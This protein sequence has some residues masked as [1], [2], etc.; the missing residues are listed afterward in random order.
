MRPLL[1]GLLLL[2]AAGC[3][4]REDERFI[5]QFR[6]D[7]MRACMKG[8]GLMRAHWAVGRR[9]G[10]GGSDGRCHQRHL[11][12]RDGAAG[13]GRCERGQEVTEFQDRD[14]RC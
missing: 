11:E 2:S 12:R 5:A 3:R 13:R 14:W 8:E 10:R 6:A 9:A 7:G 1:I 4:N